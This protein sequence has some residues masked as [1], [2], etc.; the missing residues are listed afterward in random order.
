[1]IKQIILSTKNS[2]IIIYMFM[3]KNRKLKKK[4][5]NDN[6][7]KLLFYIIFKNI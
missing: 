6:Y 1:M 7:N 2:K 3:V 5:N 4:I